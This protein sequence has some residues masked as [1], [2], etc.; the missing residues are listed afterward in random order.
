MKAFLAFVVLG[1]LVACGSG[2]GSNG[3][4]P[5]PTTPIAGTWHLFSVNGLPLP[6]SVQTDSGTFIIR[7]DSL[8]I[9]DSGSWS[10]TAI[11]SRLVP[12]GA[13]TRVRV[14]QGTWTRRGATVTLVSTG[15]TLVYEG[16]F[17]G[18][19]L[20]L[21]EPVTGFPFLFVH[22]IPTP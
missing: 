13:Q 12:G 11:G 15:G 22:A 6:V 4:A 21:T 10:E 9:F 18:T 8:T 2:G 17:N 5:D 7:Q 20:L 14:T 16:S 3:T 19:Q 1:I